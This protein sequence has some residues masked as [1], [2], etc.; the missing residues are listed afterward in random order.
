MN[1]KA[2]LV[3]SKPSHNRS[4]SYCCTTFKEFE[5]TSII[6]HRC[7]FFSNG[8][9]NHWCITLAQLI[10]AQYSTVSHCT[11]Y[12]YL[13]LLVKNLEVFFSSL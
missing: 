10:F 7:F 9:T 3:D 12:M 2:K 8:C 11:S 13:L 4:S 1:L 5:V 6:K